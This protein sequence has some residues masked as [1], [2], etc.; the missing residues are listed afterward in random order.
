MY[1]K[2]H[3]PAVQLKRNCIRFVSYGTEQSLPVLGK[4]IYI[5]V[6]VVGSMTE[7]LLWERDAV[8]LG[9]ITIRPKGDK[10][11][12]ET[13]AN[14][15]QVKKQSVSVTGKISGGQTQV[16]LDSDMTNILEQFQDLFTGIGEV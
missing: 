13:V 10:P 7:N 1:M 8:A 5:T 2:K 11:N 15:T 12:K 9:I 6:Y 16:E 14:I 4:R 3:N